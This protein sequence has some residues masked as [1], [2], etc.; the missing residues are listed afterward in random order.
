MK[1]KLFTLLVCF[2][3]FG[4]FFCSKSDE[5]SDQEDE[6]IGIKSS[7]DFKKEVL[8]KE[9]DTADVITETAESIEDSD[10]DENE[11]VN[12][13]SKDA[14]AIVL[15]KSSEAN[16]VSNLLSFDMDKYARFYASVDENFFVVGLS[17]DVAI[18]TFVFA[19]FEK[20]S[21]TIKEFQLL[22]S[23]KYPTTNWE[24]LGEYKARDEL[25]IQSFKVTNPTM[26]RF[27]RVNIQTIYGDEFYVTLSHIKVLGSTVFESLTKHME[28]HSVETE[29]LKTK[30]RIAK[31]ADKQTE[32]AKSALVAPPVC[33]ALTPL[34]TLF[35]SL[36][37]IC[38]PG[39]FHT[40]DLDAMNLV[41]NFSSVDLPAAQAELILW[42]NILTSRSEEGP[43]RFQIQK[44]V[45]EPPFTGSD[46]T[47]AL[48]ATPW[49]Q[50]DGPHSPLLIRSPPFRLLPG[51]L[52]FSLVGGSGQAP[53]PFIH[54]DGFLG[55]GLRE[56]DTSTY[57]CFVRRTTSSHVPQEVSFPQACWDRAVEAGGRYTLDLVDSYHGSWGWVGLRGI[58]FENPDQFENVDDE[59]DE[60][61][62]VEPSVAPESDSEETENNEEESEKVDE[63]NGNGNGNGDNPTTKQNMLAALTD[64]IHEV[65]KEQ[66]LLESYMEHS[67]Q[68]LSQRLSDARKT[69]NNF[70]NEWGTWREERKE[71]EDWATFYEDLIQRQSRDDLWATDGQDLVKN[72]NQQLQDQQI[73]I[74]QLK[75][76]LDQTRFLLLI[77]FG[78]VPFIIVYFMKKMNV[79]VFS[80]NP[81]G[82]VSAFSPTRSNS[83]NK[84][85]R[86]S[87]NKRSFDDDDDDY[88]EFDDNDN[89][90]MDGGVDHNF[91]GNKGTSMFMNDSGEAHDVLGTTNKNNSNSNNNNNNNI[92]IG[93]DNDDNDGENVIYNSNSNP[94]IQMPRGR[95]PTNANDFRRQLMSASPRLHASPSASNLM[96]TWPSPGFT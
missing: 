53:A 80:W 4:Q 18:D 45:T 27:M 61:D 3:V 64:K 67:L 15:A 63:N 93:Y 25:G 83:T 84:S 54:G 10:V 95:S 6:N 88:E 7:H 9:T 19:N 40:A 49:P 48:V 34:D 43:N 13:A 51:R 73:L 16:G 35:S 89:F 68:E 60:D 24:L 57:V 47:N 22:G 92:I 42:K 71:L 26:I 94:S 17:E 30:I 2:L 81:F 39:A 44:D 37:P 1:I 96:N 59:N 14:G 85:Y 87:N 11:R 82:F 65:E 38:I 76:T 46:D 12:F 31:D 21:S 41:A 36:F 69:V 33:P 5:F 66:V 86:S 20:Y 8:E 50:R 55:L 78:A 58:Q 70:K 91:N 79:D 56:D 23:D 77:I 72:M 62:E 52:R 75:S 90:L 28:K 32:D 74:S 29:S